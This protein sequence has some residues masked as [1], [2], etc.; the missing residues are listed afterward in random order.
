MLQLICSCQIIFLSGV[1]ICSVLPFFSKFLSLEWLVTINLEVA[2]KLCKHCYGK[3]MIK[4]MVSVIK[5]R[6]HSDDGGGIEDAT[7]R[8]IEQ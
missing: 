3:L 7:N 5:G 1:K 8:R 4:Q 6:L 2:R